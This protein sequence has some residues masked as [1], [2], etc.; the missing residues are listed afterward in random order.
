MYV[1]PGKH[2]C[3]VLF[4]NYQLR[5]GEVKSFPWRPSAL[6]Y[7]W[8]HLINPSSVILAIQTEILFNLVC[9]LNRGGRR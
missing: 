7:W 3:Q 4:G 5:Q 9:E 2:L 1:P 8:K 6:V